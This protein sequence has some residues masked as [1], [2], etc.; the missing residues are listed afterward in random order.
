[1]SVFGK[2]RRARRSED[3]VLPPAVD[4]W[5]ERLRLIPKEE[6]GFDIGL[7]AAAGRFSIEEPLARELAARGLPCAWREREPFFCLTD[8]HYIGLRIGRAATHR[9][10]MRLWASALTDAAEQDS[11]DVEVRCSPYG[12]PGLDVEVLVPPGRWEPATIG[13]NRLATSFTV[14]RP[15]RWPAFDPRLRDLLREVGALDFC[16][17]PGKLYGNAEFARETGMADCGSA[18]VLLAEECVKRGVEARPSFGLLLA[19][20]YATPHHWT[21]IRA[22]DGQWVAADPLLLALL[23]EHTDLDGDAWPPDRSPGSVLIRVAERQ[24]PLVRAGEEPL[25]ASFLVRSRDA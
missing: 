2:R 9:T 24:V 1:M 25:E 12:R 21:D 16:L 14:H 8:L 18:A 11:V 10:A 5:I 13:P 7:R 19:R 20:P 17:M 23:A 3:G 4:G 6:R 15:G 22:P